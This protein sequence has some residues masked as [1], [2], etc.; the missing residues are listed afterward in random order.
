MKTPSINALRA[1]EAAARLD[2]GN[3]GIRL[4]VGR[5]LVLLG[6]FEQGLEDS[7]AAFV[8]QS[9]PELV[10][11]ALL[12]RALAFQGLGDLDQ[13]LIELEEAILIYADSRIEQVG[14]QQLR[15]ARCVT[16][17]GDGSACDRPGGLRT[18]RNP[19]ETLGPAKSTSPRCSRR[20]VG[21]SPTS[22]KA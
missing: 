17:L 15:Q 21:G 13:A 9:S 19:G 10:T 12:T 3:I 20:I 14:L 8:P 4:D 1:F 22:H 16:S 18:E 6:R 2:P 5:V 11:F 7:N